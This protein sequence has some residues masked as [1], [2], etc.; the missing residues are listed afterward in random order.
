MNQV[1]NK[2]DHILMAVL[3]ISVFFG[4]SISLGI[5]IGGLVVTAFRVAIPLI[6]FLFLY[7]GYR[8]KNIKFESLEKSFLLIMGIW[9]VYSIFLLAYRGMYSDKDALKEL[10]QLILQFFIVISV[11]IALKTEEMEKT[12]ISI[13]R[14]SVVALT[15]LGIF[16]IATG[17]HLSTSYYYDVSFFERLSSNPPSKATGIFYNENDYCA[18]LAL[19]SPMFFPQINKKLYIN[20]LRVVELSL[21]EFILLKDD[22]VICFFAVIVGIIIYSMVA[23]I[24]YRWLIIGGIYAYALEKVIMKISLNRGAGQGLGSEIQAQFSNVSAQT[25]SAYIRMNTYVTEF[26]G[27]FSESKGLGFGPYGVNKFLTPFDHNYVLSNPH[28]LWLEILGNY[29]IGIFVLFVGICIISLAVL[30]TN[31][32]KTDEIRAVLIPMDIML[33]IIGFASSN[34]IGMAYWWLVIGLS[35]S[36]AAKLLLEGKEKKTIKKRHALITM[37]SLIFI[38]TASYFFMNSSL[39]KYKL[40]EP[41]KPVFSADAEFDFHRFI[42][43]DA[44]TVKVYL[45][46][47]LLRSE[48]S[49]KG[50]FGDSIR[51][52]KLKRG[53]HRYCFEYYNSEGKN[54]GHEGYF[55]NKIEDSATLIIPEDSII[56]GRDYNKMLNL[57]LDDFYLDAKSKENKYT[58]SGAYW[59][60]HEEIYGKNSNKMEFDENGIPKIEVSKDNFEYESD[61]IT[62]YA[63]R[64]YNEFVGK[65]ESE[66]KEKFLKCCEWLI[67]NQKSDGSIPIM[68]STSY[69]EEPISKGWIS[70]KTQGKALSIFSRAYTLTSDE[71]YLRAGAKTLECLLDKCI[72]TYSPKDGK[73]SKHFQG[74]LSKDSSFESFED[75]TG[76]DSF[77]RL[78][79][80]LYAVIGLYDWSN[81]DSTDKSRESARKQFED[82]INTLKKS[83]ALYDLNGYISVDL[84]HFSAQ[85]LIAFDD[86]YKVLRTMA[87][88]KTVSDISGDEIIRE[89]YNKYSE[90]MQNDFY[91]QSKK[92]LPQ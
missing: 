43:K 50:E 27:T 62:E 68:R 52:D 14:L 5:K 31:G 35:V 1:K 13:C 47:N 41:L 24:K 55:L 26:T 3:V 9:F 40:Q 66:A 15:L 85:K 12:L 70:A 33:V 42:S 69:R 20:A 83:I 10:I 76:L 79:T 25:G 57:K 38:V 17:M 6:L 89:S 46:N 60:T 32:K 91:K 39:V 7:R 81:I 37:F 74:F 90:Y 56:R 34:Y 63:L 75:V 80:Q 2:F 48:D 29:G 30:L 44:S 8:K 67:K 64:R 45:D 58:S 84:M 88:L 72:K 18:C 61:F 21:M 71:K 23:A 11:F 49:V 77:Y 73:D 65:G 53:W 86:E 22:A 87:M 78:D 28:S 51:L 82:G 92:L 59:K 16:E 36:Y 19:F 54:C 4:S